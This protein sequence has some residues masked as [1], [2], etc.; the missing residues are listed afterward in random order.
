MNDVTVLGERRCSRR[1]DG[2]NKWRDEGIGECL[3]VSNTVGCHYWTTVYHQKKIHKSQNINTV[4]L[5]L[6]ETVTLLQK[7]YQPEWMNKL[8]FDVHSSVI[9]IVAFVG[10][11]PIKNYYSSKEEKAFFY[12][13]NLLMLHLFNFSRSHKKEKCITMTGG[14]CTN[15]DRTACQV[16]T[17]ISLN[18]L[19][20]WSC[21]P[22]FHEVQTNFPIWVHY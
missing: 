7:L 14:C 4:V 2:S 20:A 21:I 8:H 11:C 13:F 10:N 1:R 15:T 9:Y 3:K 17:F 5:I 12:S 6:N 22:I 19:I 18:E 16:H